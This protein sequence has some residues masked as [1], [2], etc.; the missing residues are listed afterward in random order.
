MK[1]KELYV[2]DKKIIVVDDLFTA[3]ELRKIEFVC[4]EL[5]LRRLGTSYLGNDRS[6]HYAASEFPKPFWESSYVKRVHALAEEHFGG[7][8]LE[9][10][11]LVYREIVH[12]D[13]LDYHTDTEVPDR[14]TSVLSIN[15]TW[16]KNFR[17][18]LIF[19]GEDEVGVSVSPR[20][21]RLVVFDGRILHAPSAPSRL[22]F[23]ARKTLI[24]NFNAP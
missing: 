16:E 12:G 10:A 20:P 6:L 19:V 4:G 3:S 13:H 17:G 5:A 9:C 23:H 21:G 14:I 11:R 1:L 22:F 8:T 2:E 24:C 15:P 18:E 7:R